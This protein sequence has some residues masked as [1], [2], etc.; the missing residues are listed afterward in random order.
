MRKNKLHGNQHSED[1]CDDQY[2]V[3][4]FPPRRTR[5]VCTSLT[6]KKDGQMSLV[7]GV[8]GIEDADAAPACETFLFPVRNERAIFPI[9]A[10]A[11]K[12]WDSSERVRMTCFRDRVPLAAAVLRTFDGRSVYAPV[13]SSKAWLRE[14]NRHIRHNERTVRA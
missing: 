8:L 14:G 1:A 7:A 11:L 3:W 10:M 4:R 6:E 12:D 2:D 13:A 5:M 9:V